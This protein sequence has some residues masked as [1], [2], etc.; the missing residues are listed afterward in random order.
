M[1]DFNFRQCTTEDIASIII[2]GNHIAIIIRRHHLELNPHPVETRRAVLIF[3]YC[4][5]AP[6]SLQ[7]SGHGGTT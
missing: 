4:Y 2:F 3:V 5:R 6:G 1:S 7:A